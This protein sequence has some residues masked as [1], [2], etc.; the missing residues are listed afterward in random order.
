MPV[1]LA[2][3]AAPPDTLEGPWTEAREV[4]PGLLLVDS[5]ESLSAVFHALKWSLPDDAALLV[6]PVPST[7]K[8]RGM[9]PGTTT[10]LRDRTERP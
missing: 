7:P 10:W 5:T 8:S 6:S 2:W 1:Y 3:T 4:A 9:A